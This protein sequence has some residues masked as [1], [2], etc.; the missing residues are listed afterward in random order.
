MVDAIYIG[1]AAALLTTFGFVPQ[2]MKM[3]KKKSAKDVS[4]V[5]LLQFSI[6]VSLWILYGVHI[7]D[8]II[9]I[10]NI[11][12]VL[13]LIIAIILYNRYNRS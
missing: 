1:T 11:L 10:S 12:T 9:V 5:T 2:I 8:Y 3:Y 13:T 4:I 6:G 7:K